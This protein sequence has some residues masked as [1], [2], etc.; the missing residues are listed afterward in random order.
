LVIYDFATDPVSEFPSIEEIFYI[1]FWCPPVEI[2]VAG[3]AGG[4]GPRQGGGHQVGGVPQDAHQQAERPSPHQ[5]TIIKQGDFFGILFM[6]VL[7]STLLRLPPLRFHYVG[8]R[9]DRTQDSCDFGIWL[10]DALT[11]RLHLIHG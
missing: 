11:T 3:D 1:S 4:G 5:T 9:W 2:L 6:Y 8:G 7:Y 10:S